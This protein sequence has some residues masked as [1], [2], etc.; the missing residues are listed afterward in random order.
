MPVPF[1][2]R[3]ITAGRVPARSRVWHVNVEGTGD[4][5]TIQAAVDSAGPGDAIVRVGSIKNLRR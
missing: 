2:K 3:G 1:V 5:Q 4:A